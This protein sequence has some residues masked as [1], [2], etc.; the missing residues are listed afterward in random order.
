MLLYSSDDEN[1]AQVQ[2]QNKEKFDGC[3][4]FMNTGDPTVMRRQFPTSMM[5][6]G[7]RKRAKTIWYFQILVLKVYELTVVCVE[8]Y[9]VL[10]I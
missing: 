8:I 5:I 3:I 9:N 4:K 1:F 7:N 6:L 10:I 2:V